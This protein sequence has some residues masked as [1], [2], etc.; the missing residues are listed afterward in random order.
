MKFSHIFQATVLVCCSTVFATPAQAQSTC[1]HSS[2]SYSFVKPTNQPS[3]LC[4]SHA[5]F[6][7][8]AGQISPVTHVYRAPISSPPTYAQPLR[9]QM[10]IRELSTP[11][12]PFQASVAAHTPS[13][14]IQ[15]S[16]TTASPTNANFS[17]AYNFYPRSN[18]ANGQCGR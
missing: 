9:S 16:W 6:Y 3:T 14:R 2:G 15:N 11:A 17:R 4:G 8:G 5:S 7:R 12:T 10:P 13:G 18:C 1:G